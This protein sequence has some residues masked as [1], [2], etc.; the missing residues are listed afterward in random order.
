MGVDSVS[1]GIYAI[2]NI[3]SNKVYI[4]S[5]INLKKRWSLHCSALRRGVHHNPH[6]QCSW[7]KYGETAFEFGILEYL[8]SPEELHLAEQFW[9]DVYREEGKELYNYGLAARSPML[10]RPCSEETRRK[11]SKAHK[12]KTLS[13]EHR[14][15]LSISH[16][17]KKLSEETKRK[18]SEARRGRVFS[19]E[20]RH[21]LS[22]AAMG[23]KR[24]LGRRH[25]NDAKCKIAN[26][27]AKAY[28]MFIHEETGKTIPAGYNLSKMCREHGLS[29]FCMR[30]V[31]RG[32]QQFHKNWT[33]QQEKE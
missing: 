20:T 25:T 23:N 33:L 30:R 32:E 6:F 1:A 21:K 31:A 17:G 9:M 2:T 11:I 5:A 28:P 12:G 7:N 14:C 24:T 29:Y 8:D 26:A 10:G 19:K 3:K 18:M 27:N 22:V 4:G 16:K 15:K 13:E